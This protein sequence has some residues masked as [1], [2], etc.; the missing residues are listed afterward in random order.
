[1]FPPDSVE[2]AQQPNKLYRTCNLI[3]ILLMQPYF[4]SSYLNMKSLNM[5]KTVI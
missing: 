5:M 4:N 2:F 1:M 3:L